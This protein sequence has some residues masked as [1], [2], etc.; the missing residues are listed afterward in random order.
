VRP[1]GSV[2]SQLLVVLSVF[3][4]LIAVAA[5][6]GYLAVGSQNAN[7]RQL[8]GRDYVLQQT[9]GHLQANFTASQVAISG[10]AL[11]GRRALLRPVPGERAAFDRNLAVLRSLAPPRLRGHVAAMAQAGRQL[12]TAGGKVARLPPAARSSRR[13]AA[14]TGPAARKFDGSYRMMQDTLSADVRHLTTHSKHTLGTALA[15]SG[16]ALGIAV[17]LVLAASLSTLRTITRPLRNL[18]A[19]VRRLT[20]GDHAARAPATGSAEVREVAQA[21]NAQA[22]EADRL[23]G[24][25]AE[26]SRLRAMAREAGLRIREHLVEADVLNEA[27]SALEQNLS[28]DVVYLRL[29]HEGKSDE[30]IGHEPDDLIKS[31]VMRQPLAPQR[32][33]ELRGLLSAQASYVIQDAQGEEGEWIPAEMRD[34]VR[35]AGVVAQLITPFGAGAEVLGVIVAQRL[36]AGHPWSRAEIDAVESIGADLGRGLS[37]ARMYEAEN[38][39]VRDLTSLDQAKSDFFA[40]VSHELRA[41]LTSIEGY[42]EMLRLGDAGPV[43]AEQQKMLEVVD[44]SAGRLRNLIEDVFTLSKLE[45]GAFGSASRP[46]NMAQVIGGAVDAVRPSVAAGGIALDVDVPEQGLVVQGDAGQLDQA[47][48]NVLS[49][50]VKF[51]Q[52]GGSLAVTAAAEDSAAVVRVADTGIGIPETDQRELFARFFR[53]SNARQQTIPGTG[54]GLAIV[55]TIVTNHNGEV[56]LQSKEGEGTTVTMRLPLARSEPAG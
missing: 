50:S 39:L 34:A 11:S 48:I 20:A 18:T 8:T 25:E 36:H 17:L 24:Q 21:V 16:L 7:A 13:L 26:S 31:G 52:R 41:P 14:S 47:L 45:S 3:A 35:A 10:Y 37:H 40:T 6:V 42:V 15:W 23:R 53:A 49:N 12:F 27:R 19:T 9:A 32:R 33:E 43:S 1:R 56:S 44:R 4:V 5:V 22:D 2:I 55:R 51:T 38:Q 54:L 30:V 29:L 46:V 28:T